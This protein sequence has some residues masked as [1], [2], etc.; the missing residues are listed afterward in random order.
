MNDRKRQ[1]RSRARPAEPR[2]IRR[3]RRQVAEFPEVAGKVLSKVEFSTAPGEH[4]IT[5]FFADK[6]DLCLSIDPAFTITADYYGWKTGS[7]RTLKQWPGIRSEA[8]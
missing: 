5:L 6:S 4:V 8:N 3:L 1:T 2:K 7:Q